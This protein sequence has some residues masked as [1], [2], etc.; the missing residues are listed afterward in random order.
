VCDLCLPVPVYV[1]AGVL[2]WQLAPSPRGPFVTRMRNELRGGLGSKVTQ[3]GGGDNL[4]FFAATVT[5]R[6]HS[7][8]H[9][10]NRCTT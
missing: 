5:L 9:A 8:I 3:G 10:V 6:G 4:L 2:C 1:A 7:F